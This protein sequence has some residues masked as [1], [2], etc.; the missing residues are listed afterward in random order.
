MTHRAALFGEIPYVK[1]GYAFLF[2]RVGCSYDMAR[3]F[4]PNQNKG[5]A[6]KEPAPS[7][8]EWLSTAKG[9]ALFAAKCGLGVMWVVVGLSDIDMCELADEQI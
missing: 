8:D 1:R 7:A 5:W 6:R 9:W 3:I 2:K 4:L